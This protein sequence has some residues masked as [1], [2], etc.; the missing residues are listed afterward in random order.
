MKLE[1]AF[2][3]SIVLS[4]V[5]NSAVEVEQC[6]YDEYSH[7]GQPFLVYKVDIFAMVCLTHVGHYYFLEGF[8]YGG[9][10]IVGP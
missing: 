7:F 8:R 1:G 2:G 9:G 4:T 5:S 10:V 3:K 6:T